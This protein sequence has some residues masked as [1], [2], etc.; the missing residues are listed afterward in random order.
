MKDISS[1]DA[2]KERAFNLPKL[3]NRGLSYGQVLMVAWNAVELLKYLAWS[4]KTYSSELSDPKP[5]N[6]GDF[7]AFMMAC[8]FQEDK[9][10]EIKQSTRV[11]VKK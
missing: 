2:W 1:M 5:N 11:Y 4:P 10:A 6:A 3:A 9:R 8:G 7:V